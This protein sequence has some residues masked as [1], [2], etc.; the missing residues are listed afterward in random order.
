ML[1]VPNR[2]RRSADFA[3]VMATIRN[4]VRRQLQHLVAARL[5][6]WPSHAALVIRVLP[7]APSQ[8]YQQ[9]SRSLDGALVKLG[10]PMAAEPAAASSGPRPPEGPR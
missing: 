3:A 8:S 5:P 2:L 9:L 4:R 1:P 6:Q 10:L 7:A